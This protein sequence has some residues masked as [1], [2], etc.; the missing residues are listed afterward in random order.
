MLLSHPEKLL[1]DHLRNV[2]LIGDAIFKQKAFSLRAF[3]KIS[4]A[5]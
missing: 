2:F 5:V 1:K 3:Q 4:F